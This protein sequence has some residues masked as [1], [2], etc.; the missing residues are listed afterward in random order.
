MT[1]G[2]VVVGL[3]IWIGQSLTG[4]FVSKAQAAILIDK[5]VDF[6]SIA[7][8]GNFSLLEAPGLFNRWV[9]MDLGRV[10]R[11]SKLH[12]KFSDAYKLHLSQKL[13]K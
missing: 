3:I 11:W 2:L 13:N 8:I 1:I 10:P 5:R 12:R 4:G 9:I 7:G 6:D